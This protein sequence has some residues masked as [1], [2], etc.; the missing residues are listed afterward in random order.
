MA[1]DSLLRAELTD[2]ERDDCVDLHRVCP[3]CWEQG[4]NVPLEWVSASPE[5]FASWVCPECGTAYDPQ[6]GEWH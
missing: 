6:P 4:D 5:T 3:D 2:A 1:D